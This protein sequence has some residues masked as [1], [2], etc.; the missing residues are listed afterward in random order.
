[1]DTPFPE[2]PNA[3][4]LGL[5]LKV[6]HGEAPTTISVNS[7]LEWRQVENRELETK[8][9]AVLCAPHRRKVALKA[10]YLHD[11]S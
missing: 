9:N 2:K 10:S 1:M 8:T 4:L 5:V 7:K 3:Y 11:R 6:T